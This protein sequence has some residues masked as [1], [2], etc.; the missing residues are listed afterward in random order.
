MA[1]NEVQRYYTDVEF[2]NNIR[3]PLNTFYNTFDKLEKM[4]T[5]LNSADASTYPSIPSG[6]LTDIGQLRTEINSF[7]VSADVLSFLAKT[8]D[9]IRI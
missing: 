8:K 2:Y 4:A 7:L 5:F 3:T 6:T 9:F 1:Q